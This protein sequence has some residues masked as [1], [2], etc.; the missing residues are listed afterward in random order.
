MLYPVN[1]ELN[2][3]FAKPKKLPAVLLKNAGKTSTSPQGLW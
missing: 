1:N 3:L 2:N